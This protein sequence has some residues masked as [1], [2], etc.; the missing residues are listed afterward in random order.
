MGDI[1]REETIK[2]GLIINSENL[3][4]IAQNL[5]QE[6]GPEIIAQRTIEKIQK[7]TILRGIAGGNEACQIPESGVTGGIAVS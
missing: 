7:I 2:R 1:I 3:G 6:Y 4:N 5:R